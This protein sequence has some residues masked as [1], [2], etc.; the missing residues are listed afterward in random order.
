MI[1]R[2]DTELGVVEVED[3]QRTRRMAFTDP[4]AFTLVSRTW[5]RL[6][7]DVKY[8]YQF[9]WLGR[10]VIQ[11]PEDLVRLQEMVYRIKPDVILET[12]VAHGGSLVF[13]ASLCEAIGH[14]RVVGVDVEIRPQNRTAIESHALA[15]RIALIEGSST[16]EA[17]LARVRDSVNGAERVAVL[18]D[19]NH[20]RQHV[21]DE[22]RLYSELVSVGSYI[23]VADG[24]MRD[25]VGAPRTEPD[26][27]W[28]NPWHAVA[29]F[30]AER[31]GFVSEPPPRLFD[32]GLVAT[33]VT[34]YP[35]GWLRRV[36]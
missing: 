24:I 8:V 9:T 17:V 7:W 1:V 25:L 23:V 14:G 10:P 26:W 30:L 32:E 27:D 11:L 28:N 3:G 31:D 29:D 6:G 19:S 2:I 18:L 36:R 16:D 34:Y 21:L 33:D 4:E 15:P 5:L 22:L 13:F 35:G 20:S 12:G